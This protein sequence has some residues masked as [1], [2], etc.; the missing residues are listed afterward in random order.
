LEN[1]GYEVM[2]YGDDQTIVINGE[3]IEIVGNLQNKT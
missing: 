1:D 3:N 2:T